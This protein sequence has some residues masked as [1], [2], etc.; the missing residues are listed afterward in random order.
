MNIF[1]IRNIRNKQTINKNRFTL[2][3]E[4]V[5]DLVTAA[6][7]S[8]LPWIRHR[9]VAVQKALGDNIGQAL[10]LSL[11]KVSLPSVKLETTDITRFN[12]S[13]KAITKFGVMDEMAVSFYD[14][15]DGS[16]SAIMQLWHAFVGDKRTGAIGFKQD[17]VKNAHFY[18]YGPDAP[19][20]EIVTEGASVA[21]G[22]YL[23]VPWLQKYEI[24]N[25]FPSSINLGD[26]SDDAGPR[27][28]ECSFILDNIFPVGVRGYAD[29][30]AYSEVPVTADESVYK[31]GSDEVKSPSVEDLATI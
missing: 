10:E 17:F 13:I 22:K 18:I 26:H 27:E 14:Y 23:E 9:Y 19:G 31:P 15:V 12:D 21:E 2:K 1:Q 20:Y 3:I 11:K 30:G 25:M 7:I 8:Q 6:S 28:V 4:G 5:Q 16:A 29:G 24:W